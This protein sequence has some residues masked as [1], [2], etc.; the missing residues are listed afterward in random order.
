MLKSIF[1]AMPLAIGGPGAAIVVPG[2]L[3][4]AVLAR[5]G[6]LRGA[7]PGF[8]R[9]LATLAPGTYKIAHSLIG[10]KT[11]VRD[12]QLS[13][14]AIVEVGQVVLDQ[15]VLEI[16]RLDYLPEDAPVGPR[17]AAGARASPRRANG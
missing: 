9:A 15:D 16:T 10:Y 14:E 11:R 5:I 13:A 8:I 12:V 2:V 7:D 3:P 4:G 6:P 17:R 1:S